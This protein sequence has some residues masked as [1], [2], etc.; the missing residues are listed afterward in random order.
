M[1]QINESS[2]K[3]AVLTAVK[4]NGWAL[5][6]GAESLKADRDVVLA[7]VTRDG[8]TLEF[9]DV[10][11]K[12]D[13][14]VVLAAVNQYGW[15][16]KFADVSLKADRDVILAVVQQDGLALRI[17]DES[18]KADRDVVFAAVQ[19]NGSALKFADESRKADRDVVLA[20]IQQ[21]GSALKYADESLRNNV[22]FF[23]HIWNIQKSVTGDDYRKAYINQYLLKE[24]GKISLGVGLTIASGLLLSGIIAL[25]FPALVILIAA[26]VIGA[27]YT[28][29]KVVEHSYGFFKAQAELSASKILPAFAL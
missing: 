3:D 28:I 12:A 29:N 6:F 27:I 13:K 23:W 14:D 16:V 20:A 7:A 21:N 5:I 11:L 19:Q 17:V 26:T 10:V 25:P 4:Q 18:R 22:S 2:S 1:H 8:W 9:A 24:T 15:A